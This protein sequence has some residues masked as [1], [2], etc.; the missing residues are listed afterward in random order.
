[1]SFDI[2]L[3]PSVS[4]ISITPGNKFILAF[5]ITNNTNNELTLNSSVDTW[6]PRG[7][8][9]QVV[10]TNIY[11]DPNISFSLN[12]SDLSLGQEFV[13]GPAQ[14][15][16]LVL[17]I[18][19]PPS[20]SRRDHYY[21]FFINQVGSEQS[22]AKIGAHIIISTQTKQ[23]IDL[24]I[25]KFSISPFFKDTFFKPITINATIKNNGKQYT[26]TIGKLTITKN[27]IK[28]KEFIISPDTVLAGYNRSLRCANDK[29]E[30]IPCSLNPPFWPGIYKVSLE[31]NS[32]KAVSFETAFFVFPFSIIITIGFIAFFFLII[33]KK[34]KKQ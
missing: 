18:N 27:D 26:K 13:I 28:I 17:K 30:I 10:Y 21:T 33:I 9:G 19:A 6:L 7:N 8:T 23:E 3:S 22:L 25:E 5:N 29:A 15:K 24:N 2:T 34:I 12:N 20:V 11:A 14:K 32:Q 16:Q 31:L 4:E 1:M